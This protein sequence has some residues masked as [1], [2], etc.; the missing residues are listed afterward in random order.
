MLGDSPYRIEMYASEIDIPK[1][2]HDQE[3]AI[4][5]DAYQGRDFLIHV[6]EIDPAATTV[7]GVPKYRIKLDF[8]ENE[9]SSLKIGMT[10]DVDIIT[11]IRDDVVMVSGRAVIKNVLGEDIVRILKDDA[12]E[13]RTVVTGMETDTDV[14]IISG[15]E[16]GE[17]VI[18]LIKE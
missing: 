11:G 7:D 18:V 13:E 17:I 15:V 6:S 5:L 3:G 1:V 14:E 8:L 9:E 16:E 2:T 4:E 12:L 10:G